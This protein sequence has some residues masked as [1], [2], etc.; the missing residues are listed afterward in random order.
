VQSRYDRIELDAPDVQWQN[1]EDPGSHHFRT[2]AGA[3]PVVIY[4][5]RSP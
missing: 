1:R 5:L 3:A 2:A 4:H